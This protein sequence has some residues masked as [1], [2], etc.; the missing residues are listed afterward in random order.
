MGEAIISSQ[1][2][3]G[4]LDVAH[5]PSLDRFTVTFDQP[6][7]VYVNDIIV[8]VLS[9]QYRDGYGAMLA[10]GGAPTVIAT[11]RQDNGPPET[12]EIVLDRPLEIGPTYRFT[13]NTGAAE[14]QVVEYTLVQFEPC[15]LPDGICEML[16]SDNCTAQGGA[17]MTGACDG[18]PD[19]DGFAT[20]VRPTPPSLRPVNAAAELP[21]PTATRTRLPIASTNAPAR[22]TEPTPTRTACP[23]VLNPVK[24]PPPLPGAYWL[25]L[26]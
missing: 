21:T 14:P 11:R 24:S 16:A 17:L 5:F 22:T 3:S 13:F 15:C 7:Y 12:V 10:P 2:P 23:I 9:I 25:L 1:P 26:C 18:D 19:S 4:F 20:L 6:N 8:E